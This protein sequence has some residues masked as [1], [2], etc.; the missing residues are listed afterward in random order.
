MGLENQFLISRSLDLGLVAEAKQL[1]RIDRQLSW[2]LLH[3]KTVGNSTHYIWRTQDDDKVRPSHAANDDRIFSWEKPP[4][5][6]HPGEDYNC[7]CWAEPIEDKEYARQIVIS[8]IRDNPDKWRWYDFVFHYY[9]G[10]GDPLTLSEAGILGDV[11]R[12]AHTDG[13]DQVGERLEKQIITEVRAHGEGMISG[14][15]SNGYNFYDVNF[16]LRQSEV[17]TSYNVEIEKTDQY[18]VFRGIVEYSFID[19]FADPLDIMQVITAT[20][21]DLL[22]FLEKVA[23]ARNWDSET[24]QAIYDQ[25]RKISPG[26]VP[27]WIRRISEPGGKPYLITGNWKTKIMGT[28]LNEKAE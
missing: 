28:V 6:G 27:E 12:Y 13:I 3:T 4:A 16:V 1:Q 15:T 7:R 20:P 26:Q 18:L 5:T 17:S 11:I 22:A 8:A 10:G 9:F 19:A 2:L 24:L 25:A 21:D 23:E 14:T